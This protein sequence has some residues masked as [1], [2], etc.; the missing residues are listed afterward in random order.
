MALKQELKEQMREGLGLPQDVLYLMTEIVRYREKRLSSLLA[1]KGISLHEWRA[2]RILYSFK[3]NVAMSELI[4]HS[5]TDRTA[6]GRTV[7]QLVNRGWVK[8]F[9]AP[10]DKRALFLC[11]TEASRET[12]IQIWRTVADFDEELLSSLNENDQAIL[13]RILNTMLP[14]RDV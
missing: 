4:A 1:Q 10:D 5:Q 13:K 3:G 6:L 2:L 12:F 9:P 11:V 8:R 14:F 7:N